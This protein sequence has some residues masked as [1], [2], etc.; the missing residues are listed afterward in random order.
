MG[1]TNRKKDEQPEPVVSDETPSDGQLSRYRWRYKEARRMG[2]LPFEAKA[3]A[4][5]D[6]D[7][8]DMRSM[9]KRGCTPDLFLSIRL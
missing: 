7:I 9:L 3:F 4:N 5:S 1:L 2:M 8:E 6:V